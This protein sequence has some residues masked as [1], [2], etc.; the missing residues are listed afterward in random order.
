[1]L[2]PVRGSRLGAMNAGPTE[3]RVDLVLTGMNH[4]A[5]AENRQVVRIDQV[6]DSPLG[7]AGVVGDLS[8]TGQQIIAKCGHVTLQILAAEQR[9]APS[10]VTSPP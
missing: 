4:P 3:V 7:L 10:G 6:Q 2:G 5:A 8:D 9:P 1:M